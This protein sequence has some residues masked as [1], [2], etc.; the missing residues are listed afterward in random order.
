VVKPQSY[1][2]MSTVQFSYPA[3]F[4]IE[5]T[6]R[7]PAWLSRKIDM[8]EENNTFNIDEKDPWY[9]EV[10]D[11]LYY[12]FIRPLYNL[13][14]YIRM[15]FIYRHHLIDTKLT[16]GNWYDTDTRMLHGM[17]N[18]LVEFIEKENPFEIVSYDTDDYSKNIKGEMLAIYAW[19]KNYPNRQKEIDAVISD[20]FKDR[21]TPDA[22]L[23]RA[24]LE[25]TQTVEQLLE[26]EEQ[27]MLMRL[28]KIRK[29][30]WT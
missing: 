13:K 7:K 24:K 30:L 17:M 16:K 5:R 27:A 15:R 19:W 26:D 21:K 4:K 25:K 3:P 28:I 8:T 1:T 14:Y 12:T 10:T 20:W 22:R 23:Y 6:S 9:E 2:L 18:L 29:G 11:W